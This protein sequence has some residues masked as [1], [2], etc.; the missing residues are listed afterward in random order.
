MISVKK[1]VLLL[2]KRNES[3]HLFVVRR[4]Q[5][6]VYNIILLCCNKNNSRLFLGESNNE[7]YKGEHANLQELGSLGAHRAARQSL[8]IGYN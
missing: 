7:L 6:G 1:I 5:R 4:T 8:P 2:Y 3:P